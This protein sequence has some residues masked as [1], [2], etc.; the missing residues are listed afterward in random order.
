MWM[1]IFSLEK[2][3]FLL[4]KLVEAKKHVKIY[5]SPVLSERENLNQVS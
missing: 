5:T 1:H 4:V 2:S 3:L